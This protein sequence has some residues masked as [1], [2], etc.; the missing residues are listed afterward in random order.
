MKKWCKRAGALLLAAAF[1]AACAAPYVWQGG[2]ADEEAYQGTGQ[3]GSEDEQGTAQ[4]DE[5]VEAEGG[6]G[7]GD[8]TV[9]NDADD[10]DE[11]ETPDR[12]D[13]GSL[14]DFLNAAAKSMMPEEDVADEWVNDGFHEDDY[15]AGTLSV[16]FEG[17]VKKAMAKKLGRSYGGTWVDGTFNTGLDV[18]FNRATAYF[19]EYADAT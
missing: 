9:E 13:Y 6:T 14:N 11:D 5:S 17:E 7:S 3:D 2:D 10:A 1:V 18:G 16:S 8:G 12:E 19:E 15:K 4:D